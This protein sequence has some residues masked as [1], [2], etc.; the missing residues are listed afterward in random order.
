MYL[1]D[2]SQSPVNTLF[3][4]IFLSAINHL[5]FVGVRLTVTLYAVRDEASPAAIAAAL[6]VGPVFSVL[7]AALLAGSY[8]VR[9]QWRRRKAQCR[10]TPGILLR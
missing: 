2:G 7:A 5:T 10:R 4:L 3:F 1:L 8:S 9:R 6:G